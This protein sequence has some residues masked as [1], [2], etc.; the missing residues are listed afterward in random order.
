M[1]RTAW[2]LPGFALLI[3]ASVQASE[4]VVHEWG[5]FTSLQN[6]RGEAIGG[7]NVDTEP[8]PGFVHNFAL[9]VLPNAAPLGG[10]G[11]SIG[12]PRMD[13]TMRLETPVIYFH[14][15][16]RAAK[17]MK[18]DAR[19]RFRGGWLTQFY[20]DAD[21]EIDG[22]AVVKQPK[23]L[24]GAATVGGLAWR[25]LRVGTAASGPKTES[26]VWLA[27]RRVQ[28]D[29]VTTQKGQSEQYL[30]YRGVGHL[31]APL[32]A[33][34]T[35]ADTLDIRSQ[36]DAKVVSASALRIPQLWLVDVQ[37]GGQVAFRSV[38][39][40][41]VQETGE[42]ISARFEKHDHAASNLA[43]LKAELRGALVADGLFE[44]EADALL[45][46]WEASYFQQTGQRLFFLVPR[47]W[48]DAYLP[49][50]FSVPSRI[51]RTMVGRIELVT[52]QQR[53]AMKQLAELPGD[54]KDKEIVK[55]RG[56]LY[57][58]LGRFGNAML[59]DDQ[60]QR[61]REGPPKE[62]ASIQK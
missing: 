8:L 17:P 7:I 22:T 53:E 6:E 13:I 23:G 61:L 35:S 34:R 55:R 26:H 51:Q 10:K 39:A 30:F 52:P 50:E 5:T 29:A 24:I 43:S 36:I 28:A 27:P 60:R 12:A 11:L 19:V 1:N 15:P 59:L 21:A 2:L 47:A 25:G 44:D 62:Q 9:A 33:V 46:T 20:P 49:L 37:L 42:T 45:R 41:N 14:L 54:G 57:K 4:I 32:R 16:A 3:P 18:L 48:T 58:Q 56:E 38:G 40:R 31:D